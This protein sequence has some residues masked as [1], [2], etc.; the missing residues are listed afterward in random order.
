MKINIYQLSIN[1]DDC[2]IFNATINNYIMAPYFSMEHQLESNIIFLP[3][4]LKI[5]KNFTSYHEYG[6]NNNNNSVHNDC[7]IHEIL[8]NIFYG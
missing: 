7:Q 4:N 3:K 5:W 1:S 2:W 8:N 6:F